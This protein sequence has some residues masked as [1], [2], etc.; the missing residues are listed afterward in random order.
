MSTSISTPY[1]EMYS[2]GSS[3]AGVEIAKIRALIAQESS[4]RGEVSTVD[5]FEKF[6]NLV[7]SVGMIL[8]AISPNQSSN[9]S[10]NINLEFVN[11][12]EHILVPFKVFAPVS[13][14]AVSSIDLMQP[15]ENS[16][17][18]FHVNE[19]NSFDIYFDIVVA[20]KGLNPVAFN[21]HILRYDYKWLVYAISPFGGSSY[22]ELIYPESTSYDFGLQYAAHVGKEGYPSFSVATFS[23]NKLSGTFGLVFHPWRNVN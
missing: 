19:E 21:F 16:T 2:L 18:S 20:G 4:T 8:G 6:F 15:G 22:L 17:M 5:K 11:Q 3:D 13:Y 7:G 23:S 1:G 10:I 9:N 12:S 14:Y